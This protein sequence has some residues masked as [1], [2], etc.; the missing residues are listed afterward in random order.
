MKFSEKVSVLSNDTQVLE[1]MEKLVEAMG[2]H[3]FGLVMTALTNV[4]ALACS[5]WGITPDEFIQNFSA[6]YAALVA[7]G[8]S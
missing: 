7:Q 6:M 1:L 5:K 2:N 3:H 4:S 8:A